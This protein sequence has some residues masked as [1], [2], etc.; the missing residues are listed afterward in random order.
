[1]INVAYYTPYRNWLGDRMFDPTADC[2]VNDV[3]RR[4]IALRDE[5]AL[6]GYRLATYDTYADRKKI[7]YWLLQD[8]WPSTF[9]FMRYHRVNPRRSIM[10][11]HEP[12]VINPFGW[13][14]LNWYRHLFRGVMTWQTE[15]CAKHRRFYQY[16]FPCWFDAAR[17]PKYRAARNRNLCLMMHS[18]KLNDEPGELYSLRRDVIDYFENRGDRLLDLVG[19]GWN[20]EQAEHPFFTTLYGGTTPDKRKTYS[21]YDF[22][23]CIDNSIEPGYVTYDPLIS[24]ATGTVPIYKPMPDSC[25]LIP[26]DT[27]INLDEFDSWDDLVRRLQQL[28]SSGEHQAYRD[29]GWAFINSPDYAPFSI[30]RFCKEM[31]E[32]IEALIG[33]YPLSREA[34]SSLTVEQPES[35][36]MKRAA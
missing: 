32:G 3:A 10:L 20:D 22:T 9:S 1:M 31:S 30:E 24:M 15:L 19:R 14:W 16:H 8:P 5:L 21:Q 33:R 2:N 34:E 18:N 29:R 25:E 7:D 6:R 28:I 26:P 36:A 4:W 17:Y 35:D 23:F 13:K 27:F 12:R 11:L